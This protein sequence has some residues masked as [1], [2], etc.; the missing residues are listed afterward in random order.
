MKAPVS[1]PVAAAAVVAVAVAV[2]VAADVD[3][4]LRQL[5]LHSSLPR[6]SHSATKHKRTS[7]RT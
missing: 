5:L 6:L 2:A 4:A 3:N 7:T 1:A